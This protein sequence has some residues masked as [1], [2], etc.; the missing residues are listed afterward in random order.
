LI[1]HVPRC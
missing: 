1:V